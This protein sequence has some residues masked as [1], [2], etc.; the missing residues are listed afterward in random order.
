MVSLLVD[1]SKD[2][3]GNMCGMGVNVSDVGRIKIWIL[4]R[5]RGGSGG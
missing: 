4:C 3:E 2:I 1:C 5:G